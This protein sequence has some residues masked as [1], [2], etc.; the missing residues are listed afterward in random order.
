VRFALSDFWCAAGG[1]LTI[2]VAPISAPISGAKNSCGTYFCTYFWREKFVWHLF[3]APISHYSCGTSFRH[4]FPAPLSSF[5][6]SNLSAAARSRQI[7]RNRLNR[8]L[9]D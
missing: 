4:L 9:D 3:L 6:S 8:M 2:R 1:C 7:S 5:G